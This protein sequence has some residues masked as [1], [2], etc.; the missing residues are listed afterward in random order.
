M[1]TATAT[2]TAATT[3]TGWA[4]QTLGEKLFSVT[5]FGFSTAL[6]VAFAYYLFNEPTRLTEL[7]TASRAL[8]LAVQAVLW[9]LCLPW[10]IALWM[11]SMPWAFAI[12]LVLVLSMLVFTEYLMFPVK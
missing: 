8:P 7:W 3:A 10:M 12:R 9:L 4:A 6:T 11:W 5:V 2:T 1:E